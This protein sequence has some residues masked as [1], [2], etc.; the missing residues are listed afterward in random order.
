MRHLIFYKDGLRQ[1]FGSLWSRSFSSSFAGTAAENGQLQLRG[2][3]LNMLRFY[4]AAMLSS[5]VLPA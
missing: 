3:S 5:T 1:S 4:P 2:R